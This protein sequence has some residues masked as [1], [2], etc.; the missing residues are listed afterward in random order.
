M[1]E[2]SWIIGHPAGVTALTVGVGTL[3]VVESGEEPLEG[4]EIIHKFNQNLSGVL[5]PPPTFP[6][7]EW[8]LGG[9]SPGFSIR[10]PPAVETAHTNLFSVLETRKR[11]LEAGSIPVLSLHYKSWKP[12]PLAHLYH[13][14]CKHFIPCWWFINFIRHA[15]YDLSSVGDN[16]VCEPL[17]S[18]ITW[19]QFQ[20]FFLGRE[21]ELMAV[22]LPALVAS[23]S[24]Q[25]DFTFIIG[26]HHRSI[27]CSRQRNLF[28][29]CR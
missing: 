15:L 16:I 7:R 19:T 17:T 22:I 18:I 3:P 5:W 28:P 25:N 27:S 4:M 20:L 8:K 12:A 21:Q 26:S 11:E 13:Y 24:L 23:S 29:L 6:L 14:L 9:F 2:L 10:F 1:L